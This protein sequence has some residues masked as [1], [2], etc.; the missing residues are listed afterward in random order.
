MRHEDDGFC[1]MLAGVFDGGQGADYALIVGYF[2]A[3]K[4]DI[5]VDLNKLSLVQDILQMDQ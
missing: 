5:E 2:C 4:R 1:A 3:V